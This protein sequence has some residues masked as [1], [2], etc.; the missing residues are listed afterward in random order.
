MS[1]LARRCVV[2][3]AKAFVGKSARGR[4]YVEHDEDDPKTFGRW[5]QYCTDVKIWVE[6]NG[7][8][9][10]DC[11]LLVVAR[12]VASISSPTMGAGLGTLC[13]LEWR[14]GLSFKTMSFEAFQKKRNFRNGREEFVLQV[15]HVGG[16]PE[17]CCL[18]RLELGTA[19]EN[20]DRYAADASLLRRSIFKRPA[21]AL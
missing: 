13:W 14:A 7:A 4:F 17:N 16:D 9:N 18:E 6:K 5:G 15:D 21:S 20:R 10:D 8:G 3:M 12:G 2:T 1:Q 11:L 19:E